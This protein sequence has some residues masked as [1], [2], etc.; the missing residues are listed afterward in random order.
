VGHQ[1]HSI[2]NKY[3]ADIVLLLTAADDCANATM[4][5][6][7]ED[8][9]AQLR[10]QPGFANSVRFWFRN[11]WHPPRHDPLQKAPERASLARSFR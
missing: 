5:L 7:A 8:Q 4:K 10:D 9:A 2:N 1:T 3:S 6:I 11:G